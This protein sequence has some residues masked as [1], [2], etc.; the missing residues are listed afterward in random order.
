M[1]YFVE[2]TKFFYRF[3]LMENDKKK[4]LRC[5]RSL[6]KTK[7]IDFKDR[8]YHFS[9]IEKE[10]KDKYEKE[11]K[12]LIQLLSAKMREIDIHFFEDIGFLSL[13]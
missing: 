13:S 5:G 12:E 1:E 11:L 8:E 9:C 3:V 7:R 2:T 4:C 10:K 6:R